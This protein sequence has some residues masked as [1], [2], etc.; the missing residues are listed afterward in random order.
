MIMTKTITIIKTTTK[1]TIRIGK[2]I[3]IT[4]RETKFYFSQQ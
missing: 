1:K 3:R 4:I 2:T